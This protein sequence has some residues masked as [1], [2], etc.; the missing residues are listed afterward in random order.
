[1][2]EIDAAILTREIEDDVFLSRWWTDSDQTTAVI[3]NNVLHIQYFE[4][5][6]ILYKNTL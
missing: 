5:T 4:S 6:H 2:C 3:V 1:M